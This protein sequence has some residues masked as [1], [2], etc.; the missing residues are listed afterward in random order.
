M[1]VNSKSTPTVFVVDDD[2]QMR[3]SLVALC[4]AMGFAARGF[5]SGSSFREFYRPEMPGC[6]VLDIQM[7]GQTGLELYEQLIHEQKRLPV[8]FITAHADVSTAVAAMKTG[9]IEF[10]EKPFER[11]TLR[12]RIEMAL[13]RDSSWR[14]REKDY[15]RLD[16]RIAG[17]TERDRETLELL[18]A[19]S[20][21]KSMAAKL[22]ISERAVEMRRASLM[23][24]LEV[25]SL[26][27]LLELAIT[28][29][30]LCEIA[31]SLQDARLL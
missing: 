21:N 23:R 7:P 15:R 19:G 3:E 11:H 6:L 16:Q 9:A 31:S 10:L 30:I 1:T 20:S 26:A 13:E 5:D 22:F 25:R 24:K 18:L 29:R 8:I 2:R 12:E 4:T 27:E 28:H 14:H 17:L